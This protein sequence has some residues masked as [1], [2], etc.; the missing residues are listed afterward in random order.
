MAQSCDEPP[1]RATFWRMA[2]RAGPFLLGP[3]ESRVADA[4]LPFKASAADTGGLVS[5]C[6]F[7]LDAWASGPVLHSHDAVD[8]AFFVVEGLLE[9]ALGD[10]RHQAAAGSFLWVPRQTPHTFTNAGPSRL[11]VLALA[12]P[13]GIEEMFAAHAAHIEA[14]HGSPDPEV[15]DAIGRRFGASTLGPPI[16][17]RNAPS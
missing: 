4:M 6:E 7:V 8:E 1:L 10:E 17:A 2:E 11:H 15:M 13:G 3:G 9:A 14:A 5:I 12:M 16:R